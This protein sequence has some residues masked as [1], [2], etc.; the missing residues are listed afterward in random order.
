M[1]NVIRNM[2]PFIGVPKKEELPPASNDGT[3]YLL[4]SDGLWREINMRWIRVVHRIAPSSLPTPYGTVK[5][6]V[7]FNC[8]P[9][10]AQLL[11]DFLMEAKAAFPN[12]VAG[13]FVWNWDCEQWYLRMRQPT[14]QNSARIDYQEVELGS[15]ELLVVDIHSHGKWSAG[16]SARDDKDDHGSMKVAMVV[17]KVD[18]VRPEV[19]AR[20]C[21]AG[22]MQPL[23]VV[24]DGPELKL[25]A[26]QEDAKHEA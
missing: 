9:I 12:E 23:Q 21:M 3:R 18:Q 16:F 14:L 25:D 17:G 26:V 2:F 7:T 10:P 20:L 13:A 8:G 19:V 6:E 22:H 5:A 4:A 11:S 1:D 15:D 24:F